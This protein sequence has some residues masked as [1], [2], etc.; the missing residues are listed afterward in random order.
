MATAYPPTALRYKRLSALTA[1]RSVRESRKVRR[2]GAGAVYT[3][4]VAHQVAQARLAEDATAL[5]LAEQRAEVAPV[6]PLNPAAFTTAPDS[7]ADM[8]AGIET[9]LA[10]TQL[11]ASL[12]QDAGR[13]AQGVAQAARPGVGWTRVLTPPSCSRCAV[14]AGRVYR[15]SDAFLRH[16]RDDCTTVATREGNAAFVTDPV[17][18]ARRG[19]VTGLSKADMQALDDGADFGQVV[20]VRNRA[21]LTESGR[22]LTRAGRPTPEGIYRQASNRDEAL[23]LLTKHRYLA[24]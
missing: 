8:L 14:L 19:E 5:M 3:V 4:L 15:Y 13:A 22:V 11:V 9:D 6:A 7:L 24:S 2:R 12:T 18:L 20:N 1:E 21:G 23:E 10:F 16:P 17:D